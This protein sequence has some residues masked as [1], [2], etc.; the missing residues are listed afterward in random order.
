MAKTTKRNVPK[1]TKTIQQLIEEGTNIKGKKAYVKTEWNSDESKG[2][3]FIPVVVQGLCVEQKSCGINIT[4]KPVGG[5]E[6]FKCT[7]CNLFTSKKEVEKY[8][9]NETKKSDAI[10]KYREASRYTLARRRKSVVEAFAKECSK[11]K[12][13][14]ELLKEEGNT[15]SAVRKC[16]VDMLCDRFEV[17]PGIFQ[18]MRW[19]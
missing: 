16:F 7:P 15:D 18:Y 2:Q 12:E 3:I 11:E 17:E 8:R 13:F 10:D 19:P 9:I 5:F 1:G 4:V 14:K 6:T